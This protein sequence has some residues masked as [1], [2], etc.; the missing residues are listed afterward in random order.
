MLGF[1][2]EHAVLQRVLADSREG[3]GHTLLPLLTTRAE[4]VVVPARTMLLAYGREHWPEGFAGE[5]AA[6]VVDL[7]VRHLVSHVVM[8]AGDRRAVAAEI[9]RVVDLALPSR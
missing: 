2:A 4:A 8:P 6:A 5:H 3:A 1:T 7:L 9:A